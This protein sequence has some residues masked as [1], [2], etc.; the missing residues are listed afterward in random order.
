MIGIQTWWVRLM[1]NMHTNEAV[2]LGI[3]V[4]SRWIGKI[5]DRLHAKVYIAL[6]CLVLAVMI[7]A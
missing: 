1:A 7:V 2:W 6:L 3:Q 5:P 4:A